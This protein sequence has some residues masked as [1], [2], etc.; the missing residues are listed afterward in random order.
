A[1]LR[2]RRA[3]RFQD[4]R[5]VAESLVDKGALAAGITVDEAVDL[6]GTL[7][8]GE[9]YRILVFERGWASERYERWLAS[10]LISSLLESVE[11]TR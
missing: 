3:A 1:V 7:S 4:I 10:L 5:G 8:D 9:V 11:E 6:I 2:A